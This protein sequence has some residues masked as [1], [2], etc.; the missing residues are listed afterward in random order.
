MK[1]W[2]I[3]VTVVA[4][5]GACASADSREPPLTPAH[6]SAIRDSVRAMLATF[7]RYSAHREW[8]SVATLYVSDSTLRWIEDGR[9]VMRSSTALEKGL[10]SLPSTSSPPKA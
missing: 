8:D 1:R 2:W 4:A 3:F 6:A 9:V 5:V 7:Q 10:R